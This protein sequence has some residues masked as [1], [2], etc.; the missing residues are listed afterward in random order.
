MG[1]SP[2]GD[3]MRLEAF[4]YPLPPDRIAQSPVEPRDASRLLVLRRDTGAIEHRL[5]GQLRE[6]LRAGDLL[7][8]NDS[9][10]LPARMVG[11]RP[12]GGRVEALLLERRA[13]G[14][15]EALVKPGRRIDV[16]EELAFASGELLAEVVERYPSGA[17]LLRFR[18]A[19]GEDV[20]AAIAAAGQ[21]P[22]PPYIHRELADAERYQTVYARV[23]GSVAAPTAGLHFTPGV[24]A[25][26]AERGV[27]FAYVTLHVGIATFRPVRVEEIDRHEMHEERYTIGPE[28]AQAIEECSGRIIA[29]GTTTARCLESA[30]VGARRVAIGEGVTRL[31]IRPGYHFR[32]LD[33]LL[34]NFHMPRSSLLI[35]VSAFAG[36]EAVQRAYREA[37]ATGYR[38]LSF[39]DA[40]LIV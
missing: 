29:I 5:F 4:D 12:T 40:M 7:V 23:E 20:E 19:G 32:I 39:G 2:D 37:L 17:R 25:A 27:R 6:Y 15:W 26:L 35:M 1:S 38:F 9:R 14:V 11:R 18:S 34:T 10:V 3:A 22:L 13:P 28:V 36:L 16:G 21:V 24:M 30:A 8:M 31:Y 33:G